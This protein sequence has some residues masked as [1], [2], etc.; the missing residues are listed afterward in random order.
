MKIIDYLNS[1]VAIWTFIGFS[2]WIL[3]RAAIIKYGVDAAGP[4]FLATLTLAYV[5]AR[6]IFILDQ[7]REV[8][9]FLNEMKHLT[10]EVKNK[11][12]DK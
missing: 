6:V 1:R 4:L 9:N 8:E 12:D 3:S 7:K 2:G 5:Y 11:E 10:E